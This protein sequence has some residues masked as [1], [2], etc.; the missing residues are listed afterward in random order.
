L[1]KRYPSHF[2]TSLSCFTQQAVSDNDI[3]LALYD[4]LNRHA[5]GADSIAIVETAG[6]VLSPAPS[7][8]T[9][10]DVYRPLRLPTFLVGDHRLGGIGSTISAWESLHIRGYNV[11][12]VGLFAEDR[13]EN[14]A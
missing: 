3:S 4:E 5:T 8:S 1:H 14:A 9:Q 6:G 2:R 13:Y 10:A 11:Q 7:G 12:S